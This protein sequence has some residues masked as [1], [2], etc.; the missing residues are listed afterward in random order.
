MLGY[1]LCQ[2]FTEDKDILYQIHV[3]KIL[4]SPKVD[5]EV[6]KYLLFH[7]LLHENGYWDH[8]EEFRK[9][10]WQYPDSAELD[11][12]LDSMNLEYNMDAHYMNSTYFEEPPLVTK[13]T[14]IKLKETK[15]VNSDE[16]HLFN[17]SA[18][19]VNKETKYCRNCGNKLPISAKFC[20]KCGENTNY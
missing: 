3:N 1:A 12:F 6:I 18:K 13:E 16:N 2:R 20:D 7:E 11:G 10:E 8:N 17:P 5:K 4:S 19:G 9:R 15:V 14:D